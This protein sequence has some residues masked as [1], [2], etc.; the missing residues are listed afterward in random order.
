MRQ[1]ELHYRRRPWT[2]NDERR[3]QWHKRGQLT[4]DWR[5]HFSWAAEDLGIPHLQGAHIF[6]IP[7]LRT[8]ASMPDSGA[9][10]GAA[11]AA[12]D[13]LVDAQVLDDDGPQYVHFLGFWA[14]RVTGTQD[15]LTLV[16]KECPGEC[17]SP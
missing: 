9:C 17:D 16:V 8:R 12:I 11:K 4:A 7:E 5:A 3:H 6:A 14:P 10:I 13:G 1:W 2:L 15:G